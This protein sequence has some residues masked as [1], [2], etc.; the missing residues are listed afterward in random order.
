[1]LTCGAG[2]GGAEG[3]SL[4]LQRASGRGRERAVSRCTQFTQFTAG[5]TSTAGQI[6]TAQGGG[7]RGPPSNGDMR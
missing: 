2:A 1:M 4:L 6:V 5:V 3:A 7:A